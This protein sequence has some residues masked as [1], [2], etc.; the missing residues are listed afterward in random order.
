LLDLRNIKAHVADFFDSVL[1]LS[2]GFDRS[3]PTFDPLTNLPARAAVI[4]EV[5]R[6]LAR[7]RR[8]QPT[9][10][11]ILDFS[12][13]QGLTEPNVPADRQLQHDLGRVLRAWIPGEHLVGHLRDREFA[14]LLRNLPISDVEHIVD[15]VVDN[16]RADPL[17]AGR[18]KYIATIVGVGF[19]SRS[20]CQASQLMSLADIALYYA[21]ATGRSWHAIVDEVPVT[22]AA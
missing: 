9:A 16:L 20:D 14:V 18:Q 3:G 13:T 4:A 2:N 17:L 12:N 11:V 8:R 1:R 6:S 19:S 7:A 5:G 21:R 10:L 15:Q 22:K